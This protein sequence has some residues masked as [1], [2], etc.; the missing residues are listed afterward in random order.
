M[1]FV[2]TPPSKTVFKNFD[3]LFGVLNGRLFYAAAAPTFVPARRPGNNLLLALRRIGLPP[4]ITLTSF[5]CQLN[6]EYTMPV[7]TAA[8]G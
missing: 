3:W 1:V 7:S 8:S 2:V 4:R 5:V 6:L